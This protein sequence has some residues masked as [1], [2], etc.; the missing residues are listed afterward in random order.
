[1]KECPFCAKQ[2][3]DEAIFCKYC[4]NDLVA[5]VATV[6]SQ[7]NAVLTTPKFSAIRVSR[8]KTKWAPTVSII[9]IVAGVI[10]L[11]AFA[12]PLVG[13]LLGLT[14]IISG[15]IAANAGENKGKIGIVIGLVDIVIALILI[16]SNL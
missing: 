13:N 7:N 2:I 11:V 10:G 16:M 15:T 4:H 3:Q 8:V 12:S 6:T 9:S 1:V 14:A 5:S